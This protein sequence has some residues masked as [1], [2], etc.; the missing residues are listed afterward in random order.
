MNRDAFF[1]LHK[2]LER[3]G[4]GDAESIAW[5]LSLASLS[6]AGAVLDAACGP[7]ADLADLLAAV[8]EGHVTGLDKHAPFIEA[9]RA[10]LGNA[11]RLTLHVGSMAEPGG[12]FDFIWCAGALYF[13]GIEQGLSLWQSAL[14]PGGCVAFSE[15]V[16]TTDTPAAELKEFWA[17]YE[18]MTT[19]PGVEAAIARAGYKLLGQRLLPDTAWDAYYAPMKDRIRKL[20]ETATDALHDVLDDAETEIRMRDAY[21]AEY[22]YAVFVVTRA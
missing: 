11:Q 8:P 1:T 18:G 16:W 12:P 14:C 6:P 19:I 22:G 4:P 13:L 21:P 10:R 2:D 20:R 3:E 7:G 5:A 17:G 15:P 9:A